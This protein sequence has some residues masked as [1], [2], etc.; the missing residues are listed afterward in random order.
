MN[1][2]WVRGNL[3]VFFVF[4]FIYYAYL[5]GVKSVSWEEKYQCVPISLTKGK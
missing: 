4:V 1:E 5:C 2:P 3:L